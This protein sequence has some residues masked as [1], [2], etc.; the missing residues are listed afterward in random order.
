MLQVN[1]L[2]VSYGSIKAL[3]GVS[4]DV[5]PGEYVALI[6]T[7]GAG[8][9]TFLSTIAGVL[10]PSQGNIVF[11]GQD[12]THYQPEQVVRQGIALSPEGR[13]IFPTLSVRENLRLGAVSRRDEKAI[14]ADIDE[15]CQRFTILGERLNQPGGTLS[16]G[17]QQQLAIA[18][19]MMARPSLL[20]LDEPS[21]GIAP[22]LVEQL[23]KMIDD[24]RQTGITV[25][26]VEQK[27]ERTLQLVDRAYLI[28]TGRVAK[29]GPAADILAELDIA[30]AI[31][32]DAE[33]AKPS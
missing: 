9:T 22:I 20:M 6:G 24:L 13:R 29:S 16:G 25:L 33:D 10:K 3:Q 23:F 28:Q 30:S 4:I 15:M 5:Q 2:H 21:L 11:Q 19:A 8:K 7:N 32:G 14:Q 1:N 31:F 27:V 12:I 18:R 26:I 17:E